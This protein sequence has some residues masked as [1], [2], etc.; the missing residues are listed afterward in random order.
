MYLLFLFLLFWQHCQYLRLRSIANDG[1]ISEQLIL[2]D[3]KGS[4]HYLT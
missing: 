2:N 1:I 4:D 3:A